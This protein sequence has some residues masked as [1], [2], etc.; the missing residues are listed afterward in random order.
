MPPT[1]S[2]RSAACAWLEAYATPI[3][4]TFLST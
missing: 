1:G 2:S 3:C 4:A